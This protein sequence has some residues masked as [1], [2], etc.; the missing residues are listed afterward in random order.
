MISC[1]SLVYKMWEN[2]GLSE[3]VQRTKLL[4]TKTCKE[5]RNCHQLSKNIKRE[6]RWIFQQAFLLEYRLGRAA[7]LKPD[8]VAHL[9]AQHDIHLISNPLGDTHGRHPP[10]L[11]A[12][13]RS[14]RPRRCPHHVHTP[15]RDLEDDRQV[16]LCLDC[17]DECKAGHIVLQLWI[18]FFRSCREN[19]DES[20]TCPHL[21]SRYV[22]A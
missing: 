6:L 21:H 5:T 14:L 22:L 8:G 12:G 16:R 19:V 2:A 3:A 9:L 10:G 11:G 17:R 13:H 7:V 20:H 18:A 1:D 15:L 4:L